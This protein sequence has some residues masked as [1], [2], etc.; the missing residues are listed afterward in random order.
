VSFRACISHR[1][2]PISPLVTASAI[3]LLSSLPASAQTLRYLGDS[4]D[5]NAFRGTNL[6]VNPAGYNF[7]ANER[8]VA[9]ARA[10]LSGTGEFEY[11]MQHSAATSTFR[12]GTGDLVW[13][14]GVAK[15]FQLDFDR[16]TNLLTWRIATGTP[17]TAP[18]AGTF[19]NGSSTIGNPTTTS[20]AYRFDG[21]DGLAAGSTAT[22]L[23][24]RVS[25][26]F[27]TGTNG[28]ATGIEL[29]NL[30]FTNTDLNTSSAATSVSVNPNLND[31]DY[32][33]DPAANGKPTAK[34]LHLSGLSSS[35]RLTGDMT[36]YFTGTYS[37]TSSAR[38][39][40]PNMQIKGVLVPAN[41]TVG[42]AAPEPA[43]LALL[44]TI[45]S[46]V[47]VRRRSRRR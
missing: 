13:S 22:D 10:G 20:M 38:R 15:S 19:N 36:L 27:Q 40:N 8:F 31:P 29:S 24:I 12:Q 45:G 25:S 9:E 21:T 46:F 18:G 2:F 17:R 11:N 7:E 34:Y 23:F 14:S 42:A 32:N 39:A 1:V 35:F 28:G 30:V 5:D 44:A 33:S 37:G 6:A 43:S 3:L 41:V 4:F 26:R 47:A 16:T